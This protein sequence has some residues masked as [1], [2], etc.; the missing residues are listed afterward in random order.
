MKNLWL[1]SLAAICIILSL[2]GCSSGGNCSNCVGGSGYVPG[3]NGTTTISDTPLSNGS[4][5]WSSS[6]YFSLPVTDGAITSGAIGLSGGSAGESYTLSFNETTTTMASSLNKQQAKSSPAIIPTATTVPDYPCPLIAESA[7]QNSCQVNISK[8]AA[9]AGTYYLHPVITNNRTAEVTVLSPIK[10]IIGDVGTQ[11]GNLS[12]V[13]SESSVTES[14]TM[15]A[16]VTLSNSINVTNLTVNIAINDTLTATESPATCVLSTTSN[17]CTVIITGK[18]TNTTPVTASASA[19]GYT[20]VSQNFIVSPLPPV[21]PGSVTSVLSS[22][23][24]GSAPITGVATSTSFYMFFTLTGGTSGYTTTIT[25]TLPSGMSIVGGTTTCVLTNPAPTT[26]T[27]KVNSGTATTGTQNISYTASSG[28]TPAANTL[29]VT[30]FWTLISGGDGQPDQWGYYD[31]AGLLTPSSIILGDNSGYLWAYNGINWSQLTSSTTGPGAYLTMNNVSANP[32]AIVSYSNSSFWQYSDGSWLQLSFTPY[33]VSNYAIPNSI[34]AVSSSG[35]LHYYNGSNWSAALTG[36]SNQPTGACSTYGNSTLSS[37]VLMDGATCNGN[38]GN[39]WTYS[40]NTWLN[41]NTLSPAPPA[42]GNNNIVW[43]PDNKIDIVANPTTI[44]SIF[45]G[46]SSGGLSPYNLWVYNGVSWSQ[47]NEST[48]STKPHYVANVWGN[49]TPAS[50]VA[51]DENNNIWTYAGSSWTKLTTGSGSGIPAGASKVSLNATPSSMYIVDT[52]NQLWSYV[53]GTWTKLSGT[54]PAPLTVSSI[55]GKPNANSIVIA[56]TSNQLW[57]YN[58]SWS[59][60]TGLNVSQPAQSTNLQYF[61]TDEF[62]PESLVAF[63]SS[64][65]IWVGQSYH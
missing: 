61:Y 28:Q 65:A 40:N 57:T 34:F 59:Q 48:S 39:M 18:N 58:G 10:V 36:G 6:T 24:S 1:K 23:E 64:Q 9:P 44:N 31:Q 37:I 32:T 14:N 12:I 42:N 63:D 27:I 35:Q 56:D 2:A 25:P 60:V 47:L 45:L 7:T 21:I 11:I 55:Y 54:S 8:N 51:T 50:F 41:T 3:P 38:G 16:I 43:S 5:V 13:L 46:V 15:P 29:N 17:K 62:T 30:N 33:R 4:T 49:Q 52:T 20:T 26:C 22:N 19:T 53:S